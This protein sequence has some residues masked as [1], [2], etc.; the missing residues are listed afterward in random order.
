M[1]VV[2]DG[3]IEFK[4]TVSERDYVDACRLADRTAYRAVSLKLVYV[5][6]ALCLLACVYEFILEHIDYA[7]SLAAHDPTFHESEM[8]GF[9]AW[10]LA[11]LLVRVYDSYR[12]RTAYRQTLDLWGETFVKLGPDGISERDSIGSNSHY[13]WIVCARWRESRR[14]FVLIPNSYTYLIFTKACLSAAQQDELRSILA[15]HLP[16]K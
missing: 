10:C 4:T 15:A 13:P 9:V 1:E 6:S 16:K 8:S 5:I 7:T 14:V 3:G 12:F 11:L 2:K